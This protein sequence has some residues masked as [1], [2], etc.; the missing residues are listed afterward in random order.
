VD[1]DVNMSDFTDILIFAF[2][3]FVGLIITGFIG[4]FV[5]VL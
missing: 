1:E 2:A 5:G 3:L 4:I